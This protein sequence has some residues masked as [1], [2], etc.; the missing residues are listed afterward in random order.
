MNAKDLRNLK[1]W[2]LAACGGHS[3]R[4]GEDDNVWDSTC[5]HCAERKHLIDELDKRGYLKLK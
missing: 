2:E 1:L 5:H 3:N 4:Y